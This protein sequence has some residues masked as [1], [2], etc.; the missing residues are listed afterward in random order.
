MQSKLITPSHHVSF[1]LTSLSFSPPL[2]SSPLL[3]FLSSP[4]T[5]CSAPNNACKSGSVACYSS[6]LSC[7]IQVSILIIT[8]S[9]LDIYVM[10]RFDFMHL[11]HWDSCSWHLSFSMSSS[12]TLS[13]SHPLILLLLSTSCTSP[14]VL[15]SSLLLSSPY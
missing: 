9:Y 12:L 5:T 1:L 2:L 8:D 15:L 13:S 3:S 11:L 10:L 14:S 7:T 6:S 4:Q